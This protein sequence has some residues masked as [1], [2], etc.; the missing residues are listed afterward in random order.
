MAAK[1]ILIQSQI[2]ESMVA[3]DEPERKEMTEISTACLDGVD[4]IMLCHETSMGKYPINAMSHLAKSIAEA[5][6]IFDQE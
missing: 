5:E 3:N 4:S 1:P 2:L 6:N